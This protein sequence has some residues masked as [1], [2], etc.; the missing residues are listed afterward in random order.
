MGAIC[1]GTY[2]MAQAGLLDNR[3]CTIHW[4]NI[5]GL[6]EEFSKADITNDLFEID[7]YRLTCS[8]RNRRAGHDAKFNQRHL[9]GIAL[10]SAI[11]DQFIHDRIREQTDGSEW[12]YEAGSVLATPNYWLWSVT[13]EVKTLPQTEL[14][15]DELF[16]DAAIGTTVS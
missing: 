2:I 11:S 14:A 15:E 3:R 8:G 7:G 1:T 5:D 12:S 16:I 13:E 10:A 4:E 6:A 9:W